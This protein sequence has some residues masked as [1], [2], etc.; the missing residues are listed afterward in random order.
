MQKEP[1]PKATKTKHREQDKRQGRKIGAQ[2]TS[3]ESCLQG[4]GAIVPGPP[5]CGR[6]KGVRTVAPETVPEG[7]AEAQPV[8]KKN[9]SAP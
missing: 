1:V 6:S 4:F 8:L 5:P 7:D 2:L 9:G 3:G